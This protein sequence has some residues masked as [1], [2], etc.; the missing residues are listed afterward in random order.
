MSNQATEMTVDQAFRK[1][2]QHQ[3][4]GQLQQAELL[5]NQILQAQPQFHAAWFQLGLIAVNVNKM[6]IAAQMIA[7]ASEC[8]PV[9]FTYHRALCEIYRRLKNLD[10]ALH[11]GRQATKLSSNDADSFYNYGLALACLLY[12]SPSPRDGLLSR[13]PSSA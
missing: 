1:A 10:Q 8:C 2:Y 13:M 3:G 4:A 7:K 5:Y 11:H 6:D 9:E 12:T